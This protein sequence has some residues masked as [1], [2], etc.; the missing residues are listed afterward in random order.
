MKEKSHSIKFNENATLS[1]EEA[2]N[3]AQELK[4]K[5]QK[6]NSL[7]INKSLITKIVAG[8]SDNRGKLRRTFSESLGLIGEE[9]I[10]FLRIVLLKSKNVT[11]RRAAAKTLRIIGDPSALP[12][13]LQA[14]VN[15]KDPVVQGSSV[16]A[17]AVFGE[18]AIEHLIQVLEDP[19][20]SEMQCGLA[21]W[22]LS[23]IG[24]RGSN[25]LKKAALSKNI[26]VRASSIAALGE[27]I[28][29]FSDNEAKNI[30]SNALNDQSDEVQIEALKLIGLLDEQIWDLGLIAAKLNN[31]NPEIRKQVALSLMKLNAIN[32]I[33]ELELSLS[34]E[35]NIE[36]KNIISLS[37][38]RIKKY[39]SKND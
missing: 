19:K 35:E 6:G 24:A 11:A 10:P 30:L 23:F 14:L 31:I 27:Q 8:L 12:D 2:S 26:K 28:Q 33:K 16:G 25:A 15:D 32:Q 4:N 7:I 1:E 38:D 34:K 39:H 36:L 21:S 20:S 29:S 22:G 3:L 5:W 13:L 9:A 18:E 37:I 17:M